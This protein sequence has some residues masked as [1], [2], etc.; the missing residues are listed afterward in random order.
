MHLE[1]IIANAD[2]LSGKLDR[3]AA[4]LDLITVKTN[5]L[6]VIVGQLNVI[7]DEVKLGIPDNRA[8]KIR[9]IPYPSANLINS[10]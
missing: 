5:Q 1:Q 7:F 4:K 3:I 10:I 6:T 2:I 8:V 9:Y